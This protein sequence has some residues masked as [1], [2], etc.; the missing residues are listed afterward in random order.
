MNWRLWWTASAATIC[1]GSSVLLAR[2]GV[3]KTRDG[4]TLEGDIV[5]KPEQVEVTLHGIKTAVPRDNLA[6]DPEYFD[7]IEAR[8]KDKLAKLPK[9]PS[10]KDHLDLARWL[11]DVKAYDLALKQV[12]AAQKIDPN[13]ADAATL[14]QTI[15]SQRRIERNK[16]P[17]G[18]GNTG[19]TSKP[20][21]GTGATKPIA[22]D[23]KFLT[24]EDI[25]AIRQAEWRENDRTP[26]RVTV[27]PDL[28]KRFVEYRAIN[29]TEFQSLTPAAQAFLILRDGT[30]EMRKELRIT[31]DPQA[32][33]DFRRSVQPLVIN[34]CATTGCHGSKGVGKFFMFNANTERDDVA[35]TNFYILSTYRQS[36][37]DREYL[38]IDRTYPDRSILSQYALHIDFAELDHPEVK[39]LGHIKPFAA[40]KNAIGYKNL[41]AWMTDLVAGEPL[42]GIKYE[43][44]GGA[45]KTRPTTQ[46]KPGPEPKRSDTAS[47]T[48]DK[49]TTPAK[50][51]PTPTPAQGGRGNPGNK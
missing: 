38:M 22:A 35:Y 17:T 34:N 21:A 48:T 1:I 42:Y 29:A 3:V 46:G 33:A 37:G 51:D 5:E 19:T 30:P 41:I 47:P 4:R 32:L 24:P 25:N 23:A 39:G 40:N 31:S 27:T 10:V 8:Y 44:P 2:Q 16:P 36:L 6:A 7:N 49:P 11:F 45:A 26:P 14:E 50:V 12:A 13:S 28:R 18:T 43:V 15:M 20:P 9:A